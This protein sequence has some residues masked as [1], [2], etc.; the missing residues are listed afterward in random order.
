[1]GDL[2]EVHMYT[3]VELSEAAAVWTYSSD[4]KYQNCDC[5]PNM[6]L[7]GHED[8]VVALV[9]NTNISNA[10]VV[11]V[12]TKATEVLKISYFML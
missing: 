1:M 3:V 12:G 5:D 6:G 7:M 2:L 11:V 8:L 10:V 9:P 4:L